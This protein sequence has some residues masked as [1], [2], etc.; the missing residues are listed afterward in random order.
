MSKNRRNHAP[1]FKAK[2]ALEAMGDEL[3]INEIAAK[4][5]V[6]PTQVTAWK[7]QLSEQ[8]ADIFGGKTATEEFNAKERDTMLATIGQ[9]SRNHR[10]YRSAVPWNINLI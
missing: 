3:T 6:H 1:A 7:K 5:K 4:Y 10:R 8:A 2:V 9:Q